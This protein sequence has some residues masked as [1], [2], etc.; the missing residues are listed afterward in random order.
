MVTICTAGQDGDSPMLA[1]LLEN[2]KV[3]RRTRPDALLGDKAYL[4]KANRSLLRSRKIEAVISEPTDQ[5]GHRLRR[6]SKGG[7]P[8]K[9]NAIKYKRRNVIERGYARMKQWRGLATR[10]DK[11]AIIY[12]AAIVLNGVIAWL[13][14]LSDTP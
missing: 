9:F 1:P 6:G 13:Q 5:Q 12:R 7:G 11:L 3:G 2:L 4:S 10:Y 8:P 14:H